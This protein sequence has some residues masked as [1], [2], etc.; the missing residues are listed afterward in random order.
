M[1]TPDAASTER[2]SR[3]PWWRRWF[4]ARS[5]TAAAKYLKRQRFRILAR[6]VADARG[7]MDILALDGDVLVVI[8]V[9]STSTDDLDRV[10]SSVDNLKQKQLSEAVLR[11]LARRRLLGKIN[12]R[13][14][15][16]GVSWPP[17]QK[18]PT[19]RH[20]RDAFESTG[21][22]QMFS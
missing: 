10:V 6:N 2:Y 16:L 13:F 8:E 18:T 19:F 15:I 14:D 9:R 12:V 11:Y 3:W 20:I 5:E 21:R 1:K 4:G 17:A 7:E 22:F